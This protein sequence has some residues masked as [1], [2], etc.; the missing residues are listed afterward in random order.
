MGKL[1]STGYPN[2]YPDYDTERE[3]STIDD[4]INS[5]VLFDVILEN[6][7]IVI[8]CFFFTRERH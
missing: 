7:Q 4:F 6:K 1:V 5:V 8:F 3:V 2:Q